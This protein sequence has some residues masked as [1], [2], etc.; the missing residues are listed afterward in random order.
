MCVIIIFCVWSKR[1]NGYSSTKFQ[2]EEGL[3]IV[4]L[5]S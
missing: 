4:F 3:H 5:V 2:S 1:V